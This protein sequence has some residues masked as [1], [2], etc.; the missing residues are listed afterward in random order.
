[1][2]RTCVLIFFAALLGGCAIPDGPPYLEYKASVG[3]PGHAT[4]Y[5]YRENAVPT[6]FPTTIYIDDKPVTDLA[7]KGYTWVYAKPG[8][9]K[10]NA[11]W[12]EA[13]RQKP[14]TV[15]LDFAEGNTYYLAV[16]GTYE[17]RPIYA[18]GLWNVQNFH[19]ASDLVPVSP[20]VAEEALTRCCS[21]HKP[22]QQDY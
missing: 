21:L 18:G 16:L 13:S 5:I 11:T 10:L 12:S 2:S 3:K 1:M 19:M 14:A 15:K 4:L 7:Q 22:L 9:R 8:L 17:F 20:T 6:A